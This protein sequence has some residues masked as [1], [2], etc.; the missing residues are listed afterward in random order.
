MIPETNETRRDKVFSPHSIPIGRVKIYDTKFTVP[1]NGI[2]YRIYDLGSSPGSDPTLYDPYYPDNSYTFIP[3]LNAS[4]DTGGRIHVI[5]D[6]WETGVAP[7]VSSDY[8]ATVYE[9][10]FYARETGTY[11]LRLDYLGG[12]ELYFDTDTAHGFKSEGSRSAHDIETLTPLYSDW[13][14][15]L[16]TFNPIDQS[17]PPYEVSLTAGEF[18]KF[19]LK[20][21]NR[22]K[23]LN[24]VVL[25]YCDPNGDGTTYIPFS[26]GNCSDYHY[27]ATENEYFLEPTTVLSVIQMNGNRTE[28]DAAAYS[29]TARASDTDSQNA[30]NASLDSFGNIKKDM[31]VKFQIGYSTNSY[32]VIASEGDFI[33]R[34]VGFVTSDINI[35]RD[36]YGANIV[37]S[38]NDFKTRLITSPN[39][40]YPNTACYLYNQFF[41]LDKDG[42]PDGYTRVRF[43]DRWPLDK[44]VRSLLIL[45]GIDPELIF[46]KYRSITVDNTVEDTILNTIHVQDIDL[47]SRD[48]YGRIGYNFS[49]PFDYEPLWSFKFA[50]DTVNDIINELSKNYGFR[51]T[52]SVDGIPNITSVDYYNFNPL[53]ESYVEENFV[54]SQGASNFQ[55]YE[56]AP[57]SSASYQFYGKRADIVFKRSSIAGG[58]RVWIRSY[59]N[60]V[61]T[62]YTL[63]KTLFING[64]KTYREDGL[65]NAVFPITWNVRDGVY[66][67]YGSNPCVAKILH[68]LDYG[69]HEYK[70]EAVGEEFYFDGI[71]SYVIDSHTPVRQYSTINHIRDLSII[72]NVKDM[73]NEVIVVGD[74]SGPDIG[75]SQDIASHIP[76][77]HVFWRSIDIR[78]QLDPSYKYYRGRKV[79][80]IIHESKITQKDRARWLA[81]YTLERYR[82][83]ALLATFSGAG[84]PYLEVYDPI[85]LQDIKTQFITPDKTLWVT[86]FSESLRKGEYIVS[87]VQT[88]PRP[89]IP[90]F[91]KQDTISSI[92]EDNYPDKFIAF[93]EIVY[94]GSYSRSGTT[95]LGEYGVDEYGETYYG[96]RTQETSGIDFQNRIHFDPYAARENRDSL[97]FKWSLMKRGYQY[98][99]VWDSRISDSFSDPYASYASD[100]ININ[101]EAVDFQDTEPGKLL[102]VVYLNKEATM[103]E[104]G[105]YSVTWDTIHESTVK[106]DAKWVKQGRY[107]QPLDEGETENSDTHG[108]GPLFGPNGGNFFSM[109]SHDA[110][111]G[112]TDG[113][114]WPHR[115]RS[116][117]SYYPLR[118]KHVYISPEG[119]LSEYWW[120]TQRLNPMYSDFTNSFQYY[121]HTLQIPKRFN[122]NFDFV[123]IKQVDDRYE[124]LPDLYVDGYYSEDLVNDK[125]DI[126]DADGAS[127]NSSDFPGGR[128][129]YVTEP[130]YYKNSK[131]VNVTSDEDHKFGVY[132]TCERPNQLINVTH[133]FLGYLSKFIGRMRVT[134][135][136]IGGL[137]IGGLVSNMTFSTGSTPHEDSWIVSVEHSGSLWD[138]ATLLDGEGSENEFNLKRIHNLQDQYGP[139][140]G[141]YGWRRFDSTVNL[142]SSVSDLGNVLVLDLD[143]ESSTYSPLFNGLKRFGHHPLDSRYMFHPA[144]IEG[145]SETAWIDKLMLSHQ[146]S[147]IG[148]DYVA[149][150]YNGMKT[151][152]DAKQDH[153]NYV[154]PKSLHEMFYNLCTKPREVLSGS[155]A[156]ASTYGDVNAYVDLSTKF[157]DYL[158][159][160]NNPVIEYTGSLYTCFSD[161]D[162]CKMYQGLKLVLYMQVLDEG[163]RVY[164]VISDDGLDLDDPYHQATLE[165]SYTDVLDHIPDEYG[166][167]ALNP[168]SQYITDNFYDRFPTA[169][170]GRASLSG[171]GD[172]TYC[173]F[174]DDISSIDEDKRAFFCFR[175]DIENFNV[176]WHSNYL[177]AFNNEIIDFSVAFNIYYNYIPGAEEAEADEFCVSKQLSRY[178]YNVM[179]KEDLY[180]ENLHTGYY[181]T[182]HKGFCS[183]RFFAL[184]DSAVGVDVADSGANFTAYRGN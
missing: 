184:H 130:N 99:E 108:T 118:V 44:T 64:E 147:G 102:S 166:L 14:K 61:W 182:M 39:L 100:G 161:P 172:D 153:G 180:D 96:G 23:E 116:L 149:S 91:I 45:G 19:R 60:S 35:H 134:K 94:T 173:K 113:Y 144:W 25:S 49:W 112:E 43:F 177:H 48:S 151:Y 132:L 55:Y 114:N 183:D 89:P 131:F 21:W 27:K 170:I 160:G 62:G 68:G 7:A 31:L 137:E 157:R 120:G 155:I 148:S 42:E 47:D 34:F 6:D 115:S 8:F 63:A 154:V 123:R 84:D 101:A 12:V 51:F 169:I 164:R 59:V 83:V 175:G 2:V 92:I 22:R 77:K 106:S 15:E 4:V 58:F 143:Y 122:M 28:T 159:Q 141:D 40:N 10:Y 26:A 33:T 105:V 97:T 86:G 56:I 38:C 11:N 16:E 36:K 129:L 37:F 93:E 98:L 30:Y 3:L 46:K 126:N 20:Y 50:T 65:F 110:T 119:V 136:D 158:G 171:P 165:H 117:L 76:S 74:R 95:T 72:D 54:Y 66:S 81:E 181:N 138:A 176:G 133:A 135:R 107:K 73:I 109:P 79:P 85:T 150:F 103:D 145:R 179:T 71:R 162:Y 57:G 146:A 163:G 88:T 156:N 111:G 13:N 128:Q 78:S 82:T 41:N 127:C 69:L 167:L 139:F 125:D 140:N 121:I 104:P 80:V 178:R 67:L 142:T 75:D 24:A 32:G 124:T 18:Y 9:G 5:F 53:P 17:P 87:D 152:T 52:F 70:I 174:F 168:D 29:F 90:S 1:S